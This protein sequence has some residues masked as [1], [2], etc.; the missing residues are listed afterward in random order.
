[1]VDDAYSDVSPG[2]AAAVTDLAREIRWNLLPPLTSATENGMI[3]GVLEPADM[4][5]DT[6][7]TT[8]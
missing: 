3:S 7:S 8:R 4:I 2:S 5:G 6:P 1:V